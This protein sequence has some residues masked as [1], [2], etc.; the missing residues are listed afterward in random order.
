MSNA[1]VLLLASLLGALHGGSASTEG[2]VLAPAQVAPGELDE[3]AASSTAD[4]PTWPITFYFE[5]RHETLSVV[6]FDLQNLVAISRDAMAA[7]S[8]H[9]R[10]FRTD[11]ERPIHPRL[12]EIVA[13]V[14]D[15]FGRDHVDVV[16][17]FRARPYGAP[18]SKHFAGRAMD[19]RLPNL[20]AR[21]I[22]AWVWKN[23][24]GVGVGYYPKQ[25]FVHVDVREVDVR[26]VDT[27]L[28]GES[29]HARYFARTPSEQ[30]L[31]ATAPRLAYDEPRAPLLSNANAV[32][33]LSLSMPSAP[34]LGIRGA[35]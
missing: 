4:A 35:E 30:V 14:T 11:K 22:A 15:A 2:P 8:H 6:F 33:I 3:H 31:P 28:H 24:R 13:R 9:L 20:P 21:K 16:S 7:L 1:I 19:F 32:A 23:F 26:W 25:N 10:C 29:A 27:S 17:G 18:H 12:A 5:N 34:S